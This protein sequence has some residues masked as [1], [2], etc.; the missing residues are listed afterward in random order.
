MKASTIRK[1]TGI[2]AAL[3]LAIATTGC[4]TVLY[5]ASGSYEDAD[6][7]NREILLQWSAQKYYIPFV[8][9]DVDYGSVSLQAECLADVFLDHKVSGEHGFV[10]VERPNDFSPADGAPDIRIDN[11]LVCAKFDGGPSIEELSKADT[12]RL[13]ILCEPKFPAPFLA[14]NLSGYPLTIAEGRTIRTL[15]CRRP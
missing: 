8:N 14:P 9:P 7:E 4:T 1:N 12:A 5:Q 6:S 13:Q 11:F 10:L 3:C 2:L 15:E